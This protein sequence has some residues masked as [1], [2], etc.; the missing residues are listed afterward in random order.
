MSVRCPC[1][2]WC[3][4]RCQFT[5]ASVSHCF[6]GRSM[7]VL[8]QALPNRLIIIT[9]QNNAC[10]NKFHEKRKKAAKSF[11]RV[12]VANARTKLTGVINLKRSTLY[13]NPH[14][15]QRTLE[16]CF[17]FVQWHVACVHC[18]YSVRVIQDCIISRAATLPQSAQN[19]V[20]V[21]RDWCPMASTKSAD[22]CAKRP[23]QIHFRMFELLL[24]H[25]K[26]LDCTPLPPP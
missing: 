1:S 21:R 16:N 19:F 15:A 23:M 14:Y 9:K 11:P 25:S 17:Y 10:P 20:F 8:L 7:N 18:N 12:N 26:W 13:N 3:C 2:R 24:T 4:F 22:A 6:C 5:I